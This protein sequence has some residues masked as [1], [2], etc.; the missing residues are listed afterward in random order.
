MIIWVNGAFGAGKT[1]TAHELHR[2]TANSF[3]Y[4]PENAG[5]FI[6]KNVPASVQR[7]DFQDYPMWREINYAMLKHLDE[8]YDGIV[9]A[10]MTIVNPTYFDEIVGR[11]RRDGV[12]IHHFALCASEETLRNRLRGRGERKHSWAEQQ[13]ERCMAGLSNEV[14]RH[15]LDTDQSSVPQNAE[16]IASMSNISLSPDHRGKLK[17]AYDRVLTQVKHI[18]F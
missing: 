13:I 10:P 16:R 18:R 7:G 1:Q 12:V 3:V 4:D 6:R 11:L 8:T 15:H 17:K 9:I 5:Y 2:R 14:F